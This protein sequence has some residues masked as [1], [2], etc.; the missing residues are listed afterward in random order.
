MMG[1]R[2]LYFLGIIIVLMISFI[3]IVFHVS[4]QKIN[5][6]DQIVITL[7]QGIES[8]FLTSVMK[9]FTIIGSFYFVIAIVLFMSFIMYFKMGLRSE[10][11]LLFIVTLGTPLLNKILKHYFQ[12]ERPILH[13]LIEINGYSFPSGHAMNALALYGVLTF[14]LWK[15]MKSHLRHTIL[16]VVSIL[17]IMMIG[18][19][20]V[21]LGV[22]YPTDIIGGYVASSIWLTIA[23]WFYQKYYYNLI[24]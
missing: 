3:F 24:C 20:R 16:L 19:S 10:L 8:P 9:L 5:Q 17:F 15:Y 14:I 18:L 22:H 13:R 11:I 21:Y 7:I 4:G 6:F 12:R 23:I 2:D 1:K